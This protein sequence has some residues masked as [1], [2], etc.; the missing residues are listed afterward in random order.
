M[1][2]LIYSGLLYLL[3]ISIVLFIKPTWMFHADGKWKE[4]G[5][6]RSKERHTWMPFWLF[7]ILWAILSYLLILTVAGYTGLGGVSMKTEVAVSKE[8]IKPEQVSVKSLTS[9][10]SKRRPKSMEQMNKGYYILDQTESSKNGVPVY[11]YLGP[12]SPNLIF[13]NEDFSSGNTESN[14]DSE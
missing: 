8:S 9:D 4:F 1:S 12:K 2:L 6:G 7:S 5:L 10:A 14:N 11:M 3:G 13:H